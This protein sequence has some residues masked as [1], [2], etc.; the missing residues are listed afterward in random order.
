MA[1]DL[2]I[3]TD[4]RYSRPMTLPSCAPKF[5]NRDLLDH[6]P[7]LVTREEQD[8]IVTC[9]RRI[10]ERIGGG[11]F[12]WSTPSKMQKLIENLAHR[13]LHSR[14]AMRSARRT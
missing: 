11:A 4:S 14:R 3:A 5:E 9:L 12:D 8:V 7:E 6:L 10:R 1:I 2:A 13:V